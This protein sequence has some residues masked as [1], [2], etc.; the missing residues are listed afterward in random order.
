MSSGFAGVL[1]VVAAAL[2][3]VAA[4][5]NAA[6]QRWWTRAEYALN[7]TLSSDQYVRLAAL[8][9]LGS[10]ETRDIAERTFIRVALKWFLDRALSEANL[11]DDAADTPAV[12]PV[13]PGLATRVGMR[14]DDIFTR[15]GDN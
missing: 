2:A 11:Q 5:R 14:I 9:I 7:M 10:M 1:A 4:V 12:P 6:R 8:D 15:G 3:Y 13:R